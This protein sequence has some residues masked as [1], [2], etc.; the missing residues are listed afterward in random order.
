VAWETKSEA[1]NDGELGADDVRQAGGH[2]RFTAA[3]RDHAAP[4]DSPVL[5]MTP[6]ARIHPSAHAVAERHVYLVRPQ[7]VVDLFDRLVRAWRTAR[8]RNVET[9]TPMDLAAI[10]TDEGALPTQWLPR[11]RTEPLQPN[12]DAE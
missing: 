4:G 1:K 12:R 9:L 10:F 8:T 6:Q 3:K 5:L 2:L 11:L 7:Q